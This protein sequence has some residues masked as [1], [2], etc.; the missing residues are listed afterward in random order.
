ML[1]SAAAGFHGHGKGNTA[2]FIAQ[3]I[4]KASILFDCIG[5]ITQGDIAG[6]G[7]PGRCIALIMDHAGAIKCINRY[8]RKAW[9]TGICAAIIAMIAVDSARLRANTKGKNQN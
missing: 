5:G 7:S 1:G 4:A 2:S 8:R 9:I 3:R 6:A